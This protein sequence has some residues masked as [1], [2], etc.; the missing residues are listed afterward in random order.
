[1]KEL[2]DEQ[3]MILINNGDLQMTNQ[4]F[5]RYSA[6]IFNY[7]VK[8]TRDQTASEDITQETFYRVLKHRHSFNNRSFAP[9]IFTISR[10]LCFDYLKNAFRT[11]PLENHLENHACDHATTHDTVQALKSALDRLDP[12]DREVIVLSRYEKLKYRDIAAV[13]KMSESAVKN[14]IHRA[15]QKLRLEY[16]KPL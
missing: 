16:F 12:L 7:C 14:R 9:W 6:R 2:T 11:E 1:M 8:V 3:L 5:E 10:N 15:L 4:L 13:M